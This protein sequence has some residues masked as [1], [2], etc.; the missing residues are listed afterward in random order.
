MFNIPKN[1]LE[2]PPI[3]TMSKTNFWNEEHISKQMLDAHLAPEFEGASRNHNYMNASSAWIQKVVPPAMYPRLLDIGCGPGLYAERFALAGYHVTGIDFSQRSIA[4]A[5]ESAQKKRLYI[6]Y[7]YQNYL[8]LVPEANYDF[9]TMIYCDYGALST[10]NRSIL[11]NKIY[12]SL[13]EGGLFLFDVFSTREYDKFNEQQSW[14]F[15]KKG[16]FWC[17]DPYIALT[18]NRKYQNY[19]TLR[20]TAVSSEHDTNVYYIWDTYF[21]I[22]RLRKEAKEAGFKVKNIWNDVSGI[23]YSKDGATIAILLEK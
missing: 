1:H 12:D 11:M 9:V 21:T 13:R 20:Q 22:E 3:Y 6:T 23:P 16:G 19:V 10:I 5:R 4:Y 17:K 8:E 2:I 14:D 18:I 15:C 7:K